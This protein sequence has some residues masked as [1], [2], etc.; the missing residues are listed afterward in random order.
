MTGCAEDQWQFLPNFFRFSFHYPRCFPSRNQEHFCSIWQ[1]SQS[2]IKNISFISFNIDNQKKCNLV[3]ENLR[4]YAGSFRKMW[5]THWLSHK[6]DYKSVFLALRSSVFYAKV[7]NKQSNSMLKISS[8]KFANFGK[9][10]PL[11]ALS[12]PGDTV[13]VEV[14]RQL[15]SWDPVEV[16]AIPYR[17]SQL[18]SCIKSTKP[19][20]SGYETNLTPVLRPGYSPRVCCT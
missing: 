15:R 13:E 9:P 8:H 1:W 16:L 12:P 19:Y 2:E 5:I 20:E 11:W 10:P 14:L 3:E 6:Y 18:T 17:Y 4:C 7:F